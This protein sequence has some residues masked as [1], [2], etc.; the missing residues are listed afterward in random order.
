MSLCYFYCTVS[1]LKLQSLHRFCRGNT[2]IRLRSTPSTFSYSTTGV[3]ST[4]KWY[5][6]K[7][8]VF[9]H[10][11]PIQNNRTSCCKRGDKH[12]KEACRYDAGRSQQCLSIGG[13]LCLAS[14]LWAQTILRLRVIHE[15]LCRPVTIVQGGGVHDGEEGEYW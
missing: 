1:S 15:E 10:Q 14:S 12:S 2:C 5:M 4:V 11:G 13:E 6:D 9:E 3:N 7:I 8:K